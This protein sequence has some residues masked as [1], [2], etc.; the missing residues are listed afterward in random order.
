MFGVIARIGSAGRLRAMR[1]AVV[2]LEV[3][4]TIAGRLDGLG[5]IGGGRRDRVRRRLLRRRAASACDDR[6]VELV[7]LGARG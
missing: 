7:A 4:A 3:K 2:P 6:A 5:E 1:A